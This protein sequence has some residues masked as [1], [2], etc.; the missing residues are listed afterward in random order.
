MDT[1]RYEFIF[2]ERGSVSRSS[3]ERHLRLNAA[4]VTELR[5]IRLY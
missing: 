5:S 2:P 4:R 1:N 3:N